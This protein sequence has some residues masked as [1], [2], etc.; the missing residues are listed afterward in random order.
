MLKESVG[1]MNQIISPREE[2]KRPMPFRPESRNNNKGKFKK[3]F[4]H[5]RQVTETQLTCKKKG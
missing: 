2:Q 5:P 4:R 1:E 3:D